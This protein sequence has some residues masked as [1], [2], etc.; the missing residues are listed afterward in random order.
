VVV[1]ATDVAGNPGCYGADGVCG[2]WRHFSVVPA[3]A[4]LTITAAA[5]TDTILFPRDPVTLS[6]TVTND[7]T[8]SAPS[9]TLDYYLS[10]SQT[11]FDQLIGSDPVT[12]L[13][14]NQDSPQSLVYTVPDLDITNPS[15]FGVRYFVFRA[16]A[17]NSVTERDENDN[18]DS[19]QITITRPTIRNYEITPSNPI[20][21]YRL[22]IRGN[23]D[24][25]T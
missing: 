8:I 6:A 20:R 12:T 4:N 14:V 11:S 21:G 25:I 22:Q 24:N 18:T 9:T 7:G 1:R 15:N 16:D 5:T 17:Y 23:P 13:G 10:S 19:E 3:I 2:S